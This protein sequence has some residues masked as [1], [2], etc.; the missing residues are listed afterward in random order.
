LV[1]RDSSRE[2]KRCISAYRSIYW[3]A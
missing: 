1:H 3:L 2:D